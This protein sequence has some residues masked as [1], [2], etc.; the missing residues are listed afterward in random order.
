[1]PTDLITKRDDPR[2]AEMWGR[3]S[4]ARSPG[5]WTVG[6]SMPITKLELDRLRATATDVPLLIASLDAA[7]TEVE[8]LGMGEELQTLEAKEWRENSDLLAADLAAAKAEIKQMQD[9]LG[10]LN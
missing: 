5:D 2:I 9:Q 4:E 3:C 10:G 6:Q 1:M 8:N 7:L